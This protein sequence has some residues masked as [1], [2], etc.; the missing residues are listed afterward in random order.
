[1]TEKMKELLCG[2]SK[3]EEQKKQGN[4]SE[5]KRGGGL[6][7]CPFLNQCAWRRTF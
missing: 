6:D 7:R 5:V 1:M 4:K 3:E 2:V